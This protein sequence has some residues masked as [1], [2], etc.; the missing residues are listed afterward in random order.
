MTVFTG[1]SGS[2]KSSLAFDTIYKEGQRRFLESLSAYA[3]QFLGGFEKPKVEHIDGLSP[4]VSIDQ[5][6]VSRSPRSTVGTI[7]EIYDYLRLFF[8]RLGQPHC[9]RCQKPVATQTA[10]QI[11]E[12]VLQVFAGKTALACAPIVRGRKGEYRSLLEDLR[13]DG[14]TRLLVD[15]ALLRLDEKTSS[16][17]RYERHDI[18]VVCDRLEAR[19]ELKSRW[20]E[21]V[22]KSLSLSGGLARVLVLREAAIEKE[23]IFSSKFACPEC[24]VDLPELEPRLFSFNSQHGAC[25]ECEGLGETEQIDPELLIADP[26]LPFRKGGLAVM[27]SNGKLLSAGLDPAG[28]LEL[29]KRHG[30]SA[31]S[32]WGDLSEAARKAVL[33]GDGKYQGLASLVSQAGGAEPWVGSFRRM[34]PCLKCGGSRL[35]PEARSVQVKGRGIHELAALPVQS[36][37]DW[38]A[39]LDLTGSDAAIGEPI[40]TNIRS[41]LSYLEKVGLSYLA[42]ERRA[43]TL[44]G[45]EAQRLRLASQ[46]GAGLQGVLFVLDEP[47]IGLHPR[48]NRSLL[49]TLRALRDLGNT[50]L[51][52]EHDQATMEAADYLVDVGPGAGHQGGEIVATGTVAE[53]SGSQRSMT[54]E[55]LSGRRVIPLPRAR[56]N[57]GREWLELYGARQNNLKDIDVR[58]PLGLLVAVTGVSGSGKSSLVNQ[59]LRPALLQKLGSFTA[60]PGKHRSLRGYQHIDKVVEI[61]QNPIGKSPRSN[62]ATYAKVFDPVRELFAQVPEARARGYLP[63]RFSFNKDGGRCLECF[64]GG[65]TIVQMQFLAPVEVTCDTCGGKRYN[66]ETLEVFYRGKSIY[67]VL[68][69]TIAEAAQFFRDHPKIFR[70]L[71]TLEKVGLGYMKLGQPSTTL[72]GGEAQ[73]VKLAS[74]LRKRDTGKTLYLFDEPTTGLHFED[75]RVLL[76]AIDELVSRGNSAMVI[77]H[78]LDV[79]K[80]ADYILDLGPEAG[81]G[82]GRVV[83]QG[84]P[85]EIIQVSESRTGEALRGLLERQ[86]ALADGVGAENGEGSGREP[87]GEAGA[88]APLTRDIE[89]KGARQHNLRSVDARI[90]RDSLT[91]ITGVSGSGKT[92]LAFDTLFAEGQRRYLESLSTY[93]RRFLGRMPS[94]P[95]DQITGLSPTIAIDQKSAS[96]NP[97]STVA[98]ITE[99]HDYLRL[100]YARVGKP[101]CPV[102]GSPLAWTSPSR[103][104]A[105]LVRDEPGGKA[106]VLA[107][108]SLGDGMG[109]GD[110][111]GRVLRRVESL[112]AALLK[113]GF[114]RVLAGG[115]EV[116]LDEEGNGPSRRIL[117]GLK[118]AAGWKEGNSAEPNDLLVVV[119]R[120]ALSEGT[121]TRLASAL[122]Q[123]F[124]RGGGKAGVV[125]AGREPIFHTRAPSCPKGHVTFQEELSPRMFSFS[126]HQGACSQCRGLGF[127]SRADLD[128]LIPRPDLPLFQALDEDFLAFLRTSRPSSLAVL[129][130]LLRWRGIKK[131]APFGA[132]KEED[133]MAIVMGLGAER[134]PLK[135]GNGSEI[136]SLWTGLAPLLESWVRDE[137]LGPFQGVL[138]RLLQ[139]QVCAVCKGGRLRP[140]SL[141]VRVAGLNINQFAQLTVR[142]A[143][144]FVQRLTLSPRDATIAEQVLQEIHNRLRFLEEVGL[145]YLTLERTANTLS[146]GEAQRIRLASQLGNRLS[147]VLYVL[148]EPTVGLHQRDTR[149]LLAS[150]TEL[151][152]LGN[153]IL[154][155]EHDR[156]TMLAADWIIDMGPGAGSS[157][158]RVVA[159]GRPEEIKENPASLTGRYLRGT[160]LDEDLARRRAPS[161]GWIDLE[162]VNH[163]NLKGVDVAFPLGLFTAVTG[164]SGS[165]KSSLV[166]DVLAEA[167]QAHLERR[168]S[169]PSAV[170][171]EVKGD[172]LL[173]GRLAAARGLDKVRRLVLVDQK[174]IGRTPRSNAATYT[175]IWDL[176]RELYSELPESKV[177]G[178]GVSRFSFN[179]G[180]GRCFACDG[181]G[182][183]Q[184]EMHFLSDVWIPCEA[185]KGKRF[186][187]ET[188]KI[189]FKGKGVGDLLEM[190][191]NEAARFFENQP[192]ILR[193]LESLRAV[194]LGYL[195]LGQASNTLSGG[196]S[197]RVKL[198]AELVTRE[199]GGT[200]YVLDE[201][202]TGLHFEDI[203]R[204]IAV[205]QALVE[206]GN[207]LVVIEHQLDVV[208]AA[209]WVIDLGPEAGDE[210]GRVIAFGPA[211]K[212]AAAAESHT[213]RYLKQLMEARKKAD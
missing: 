171:S 102:C 39:R 193:I 127:E 123:A 17:A 135:F 58:F 155:V 158:G 139:P 80:V 195:K 128:L 84:T 10:E 60:C 69:M 170:L 21:A 212:I 41:R 62:P 14:Y 182:S 130:A 122:E 143:L 54:G 167:A 113:S 134:V 140:E 129:E 150:L 45:G 57:P 11:C 79:I 153:T 25:P 76:G 5:R 65:V 188:L 82:G 86:R 189:R 105:D 192:R 157:G 100:L 148:D 33:E 163:N 132:M 149:R 211:E 53:I 131:S 177:R 141:A 34:R 115:E 94:A 124:E 47:S 48:D 4:T 78:N 75:V 61:D 191:V 126:S 137:T 9:P 186:D 120:M 24:G 27:L 96:S 174:P 183:R 37:A 190:E 68:E 13:R 97:R 106:V 160:A 179:S 175:G 26:G 50:V 118:T 117:A 18:D 103:L 145:G 194:G 12:R 138:G 67:D 72:S 83:A 64:G 159:C 52:V 202:T 197:Q 93:A 199:A 154:M 136:P 152:D 165:G 205:F 166:L 121:Q 3:R 116:R 43:D 7:T 109:S 101:H 44:A 46:V 81:D 87:S 85:E 19:P 176:V 144:L 28:F 208:R 178:Y 40:V 70:P 74:E 6:T 91:V 89:V 187:K 66:R 38:F 112:R 31:N 119:D 20:T 161:S 125:I 162:G 108:M 146:G 207:T 142:D 204:L 196:E 90:P 8:A 23:E 114:T 42:L 104:A 156:E 147:G 213:G 185:C 206:G 201:P 2:G 99:V 59:V 95:V 151:R 35:R 173:P 73:R 198:A 92:S 29:G 169:R 172:T 88:M 180:E 107:P 15:G 184:I 181:Q 200:L 55:Y 22:E 110:V 164:V 32:S 30:F 168:G 133:R 210:G 1:V 49:Q 71:E 209:D 51:V 203:R 98:T 56:R 16:L 36:L 77:E 63:G 111:S